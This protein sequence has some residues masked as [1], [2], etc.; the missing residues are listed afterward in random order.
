M[1]APFGI[2]VVTIHAL[3][4]GETLQG[5]KEEMRLS[6]DSARHKVSEHTVSAYRRLYVLDLAQT[7]ET[8]QL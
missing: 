7:T 3:I 4:V 8:R 5:R 6:A 2:V 1:Y